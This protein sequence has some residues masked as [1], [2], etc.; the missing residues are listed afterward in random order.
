MQVRAQLWGAGEGGVPGLCV[1]GGQSPGWLQR[2][3]GKV[4]RPHVCPGSSARGGGSPG[5]GAVKS[6]ILRKKPLSQ[7]SVW[8][9]PGQEPKRDFH[10]GNVCTQPRV[11]DT[12]CSRPLLT[13][14]LCALPF[15][16]YMLKPLASWSGKNTPEGG[17]GGSLGRKLSWKW[18]RPQSPHPVREAVNEP[19]CHG[20]WPS[21]CLSPQR[22][23]SDSP[24]GAE[25]VFILSGSWP[26]S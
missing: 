24:L 21:V 6:E 10:G 26:E 25:M 15:G 19:E 14:W 7:I 5:L 22:C 11:K 9:R 20:G 8:S 4:N 2:C 1:E 12:I 18:F 13:M 16:I 3:V 23:W 17:G